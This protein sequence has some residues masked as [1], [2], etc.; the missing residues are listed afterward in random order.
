M[1]RAAAELPDEWA[2]ELWAGKLASKAGAPLAA[3]LDRCAR[4]MPLA[5][6]AAAGVVA[7]K[8]GVEPAWHSATRPCHRPCRHLDMCCGL[9]SARCGRC[10]VAITS[11]YAW[12]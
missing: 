12:H 4:D 10:V 7:F 3:V 2:F 9:A 5:G 6:M 11:M 8:G 1:A